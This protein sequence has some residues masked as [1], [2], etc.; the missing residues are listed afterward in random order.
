MLTEWQ[1]AWQR[2]GLKTSKE[3][4]FNCFT[5]SCMS[6][7]TSLYRINKGLLDATK[8]VHCSLSKQ[9]GAI[10]GK[11]NFILEQAMKV[12]GGSRST[13]YSF[14]NLSA[15]LG[16]A[17]NTMPWPLYPLARDPVP[18]TQEGGRAPRPVLDGCRKSHH[19][20]DLIRRPSSLQQ[21]AIPT[22]LSQPTHSEY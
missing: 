1:S 10:R 19:H 6:L 15:R 12:Q 3:T 22:T 14:F 13:I 17:V 2:D 21:V 20:Q 7:Y 9:P 5:F 18:T 11:C 8:W 4:N 16:Q